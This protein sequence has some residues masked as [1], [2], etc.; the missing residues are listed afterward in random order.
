MTRTYRTDDGLSVLQA[1]E[2]YGVRA[3]RAL[4]KQLYRE[5]TDIIAK[6]QPLVPVDTGTLRSSGYVAPPEMQEGYI[7]VE[8]GYG[9]PAA[10]INPKTGE[11]SDAYAIFVHEN[12]NAHHDVG[13][14]LFLHQPF[15]EAE[16][17][18]GQRIADGMNADL[19]GT[20]AAVTLSTA[21]D[22]GPNE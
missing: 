10:R 8:L 16:S 21:I 9:G 7:S 14:A 13:Q 6:S 18:M 17:G 3:D 15:V 2:Q 1:L 4:G 11:S 5:A 12:L 22:E 19:K 20:E